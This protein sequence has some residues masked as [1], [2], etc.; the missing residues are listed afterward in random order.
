[1]HLP[2]FKKKSLFV[3]AK[4]ALGSSRV[5]LCLELFFFLENA[6]LKHVSFLAL[7][8]AVSEAIFLFFYTFYC[9]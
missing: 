6:S 3:N 9:L 4:T 5:V 8:L 1:M 2:C 7:F